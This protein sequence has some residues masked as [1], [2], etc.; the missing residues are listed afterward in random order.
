MDI[1]HYLIATTQRLGGVR[2]FQLENCKN[3]EAEDGLK[4]IFLMSRDIVKKK[5]FNLILGFL[6]AL[7]S[8]KPI[9]FTQ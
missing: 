7:A 8:L 1:G 4:S 5:T 9:L 3:A 2:R 6:D